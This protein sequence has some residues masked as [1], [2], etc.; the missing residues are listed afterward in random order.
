MSSI[1][2]EVESA[3]INAVS[4]A[5][6]PN[7]Y[8]SEREGAR[9]LPNLTAQAKIANELL[10]PFSGV[11]DLSATLTYTNRAD[12]VSRAG[13][14]HE[15]ETIIQELYRDPNLAT[16]MTNVSNLTIYKASINKE[17]AS[18]VSINRTWSRNISLNVFATSK[19]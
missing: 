15:F 4:A 9:L 12:S 17:A 18:I 14:D 10:V 19:G 2:R 8:T 13:F 7:V 1:E 3:L 11:F 5:N 16:Y 6:I